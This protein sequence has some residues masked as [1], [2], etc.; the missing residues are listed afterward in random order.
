MSSKTKSLQ[1][2]RTPGEGQRLAATALFLMTEYIE[3]RRPMLA[4]MIAGELLA[5]E[6]QA[7]QDPDLAI[8]V[9]R[10][11]YRWWQLAQNGGDA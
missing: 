3:S 11:R 7:A 2:T 4:A 8:I 5:I 9:A 6:R 10:L 1:A